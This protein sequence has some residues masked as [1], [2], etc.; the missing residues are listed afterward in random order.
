MS[1]RSRQEE[2]E[3]PLTAYGGDDHRDDLDP[4]MVHVPKSRGR[5]RQHK[6]SRAHIVI[7][8]IAAIAALAGYLFGKASASPALSPAFATALDGLTTLPHFKV[9]DP[10]EMFN[11]RWWTEAKLRSLVACIIRGN[12]PPNA[13]K[14]RSWERQGYTVLHGGDIDWPFVY[15][16][17]RQIPDLVKVI[18]SDGGADDR[19]GSHVHYLKSKERPDGIPAWKVG[20][21]QATLTPSSSSSATT[22]LASPRKSG[23][24]GPSPPSQAVAATT[25]SRSTAEALRG[26]PRAKRTSTYAQSST[27][28]VSTPAARV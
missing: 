10:N 19:R 20:L 6:L 5:S 11:Y 26:S 25:R 3:V 17:Y 2:E 12:C 15:N 13:D 8:I 23:R 14:I 4:V 27:P 18:V 7:A 21:V 22:P 9:N 1:Y 16:I 24:R 28:R